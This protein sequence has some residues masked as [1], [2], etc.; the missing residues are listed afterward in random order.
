M[1]Q[2]FKK[3]C[4]DSWEVNHSVLAIGTVP[5][6]PIDTNKKVVPKD[7]PICV[8]ITDTSLVLF[9]IIYCVITF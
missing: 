8:A 2:Y 6:S 7:H 5:V 1:K 4:E 9:I 3:R